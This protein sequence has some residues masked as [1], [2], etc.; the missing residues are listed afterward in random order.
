MNRE[1][2]RKRLV[3][4]M[5][6]QTCNYNSCENSID[7]VHCKYVSLCDEEVEDLADA[8]LDNG[9]V[10]PPVKVGDKVYCVFEGDV[11]DEE[12]TLIEVTETAIYLSTC[13]ERYIWLNGY[14]YSEML[15]QKLYFTKEQ[16]QKALEGRGEK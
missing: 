1:A 15:D 10:V 8:L 11:F 4:L 3:E 6:K 9:I 14:L 5:C 16:A 12:I 2:E 13:S 7:C